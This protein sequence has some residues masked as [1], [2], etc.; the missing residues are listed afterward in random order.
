M[1]EGRKKQQP[2]RETGT[3]P[4]VKYWKNSTGLP[5]THVSNNLVRIYLFT[6]EHKLFQGSVKLI[7]IG[8]SKYV[9]LAL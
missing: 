7:H 4:K 2:S 6:S 3:V 5:E 8:F 9:T 1:S